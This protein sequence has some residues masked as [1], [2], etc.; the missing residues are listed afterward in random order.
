MMSYLIPAPGPAPSLCDEDKVWIA[1]NLLR[2]GDPAGMAARLIQ[3]GRPADAVH[4]DIAEAL[5][6]PYIR[7]A[8]NARELWK[9]RLAKANWSLNALAKLE[10]QRAQTAVPVESKLSTEAFYE[11]YY[12]TNRPVLIDGRMDDWPAMTKWTPD[13]FVERWGGSVVE[14][15]TRRDSNP[16]FEIDAAR[17]IDTMLLSEFVARVRGVRTNELYLTARNSE[18]N[19]TALPSLWDDIGDLPDYLAP[20]EPRAGFFWFGP[21]GTITPTHHDLTNNLMA[22]V[23]GRKRVRI[24]SMVS[25]PRLSNHLHVYSNVDLSRVDPAA[26]P[27][28]AEVPVLD[29]VLHPGQL[30]F[31]PI[32]CWHHVEALDLSVTMT[33][34]NFKLDND[35]NAFYEANGEL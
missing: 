26:F 33:F 4:R 2:G 19:R 16:A 21:A 24:A 27:E 13:Y 29:C 34:T 6:H 11:N 30:L 28:M 8:N 14:A 32:G 18:A 20:C 5:R 7:G 17:H 15:Q 1:E 9:R 35:Y 10:R 3:D 23:M 12:L 31:L 25:Q 22:Q